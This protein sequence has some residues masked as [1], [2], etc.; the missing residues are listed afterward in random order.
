MKFGRKERAESEVPVAPEEETVEPANTTG[1]FDADEVDV[2]GDGVERLDLGSL[3]VRPGSDLELRLQ[4]QE[5]TGEVRQVLFAGPEGAIEVRAFAAPRG[6]DLWTD[7]RRQIAAETSRH[8]GT[9]TEREGPWGTE[10]ACQ[11]Q[12]QAP[13]GRAGVQHQ[14]VIGVNGPRW[15]VRAT[16]VGRPAAEPETAGPFEDILA[17][18]V[19][20]RG[21]EAMPPGDPLPL[22]I[23]EHTRRAT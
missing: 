17:G 4:V 16:I 7:V 8:G 3:L 23:P 10:L 13:D 14:R 22:T 15:F 11:V 19:I 5:Q 6:G 12:A 9:A 21:T 18:L 1:P 20:R 2:E